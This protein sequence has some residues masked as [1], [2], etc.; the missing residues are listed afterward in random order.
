M[1]S[2]GGRNRIHENRITSNGG[3]G[4]D[5]GN[6]GVSAN[7]T[8]PTVCDPV[9]GCA[10]NRG[11]NFPILDAA[12]RAAEG[13]GYPAGQPI[14]ITG[15]LRSGIGGPYRIEFFGSSSCD[16][17]GHGEGDRLLGLINVTITDEPYCPILGGPC[18]A[19]VESNCTT[20][21]ST[22]VPELDVGIGGVI[23]ATAGPFQ[24]G[25]SDTSEFSACLTL[26]ADTIFADGFED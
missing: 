12:V 4:I 21:F 13:S 25:R 24:S 23:T 10:S 3:L 7:D 9:V 18:E 22:H 14:L 20:G 17:L 1:P 11:Q 26:V 6:P 5:L 8:D 15:S 16:S 2:A 19:C